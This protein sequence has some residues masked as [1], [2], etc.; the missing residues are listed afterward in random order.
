MGYEIKYKF[1]PRK[2]EGSGYNTDLTE[3][4]LVKVGKPFDDTPLEKVAAAI[5]SQM[6]R[7]DIWVVDVEVAELVR[8]QIAFKE[9]KDGKG[10]VLKGKKYSFNESAQMVSEDVIEVT[11]QMVAQQ[12]AMQNGYQPHEILAMQQMPQVPQNMQPH[13]LINNAQM[14]DD[15]YNNP[16]KPVPVKQNPTPTVAINPKKRLYDVYFEPDHPHLMAEA[17]RLNLKFSRDK[18]YAVHEIIQSPT[19]R[20]DANKI[21]LTNDD[22]RIV[23]VDEKYFA[24]AGLGL[25]ADKQLGF[26]GSNGKRERKPKLAFEGEMYMDGAHPEMQRTIQS[27]FPLDDGTIPGDLMA[28]PDIRKQRPR[29]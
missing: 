8:K 11:S 2:E 29:R 13:E 20:L 16:N 22:G 28:M 7:R 9:C 5:M 21:A 1:H 17:K 24:S 12:Q 14:L 27:N 25:M 10:I 3:E 26:S 15:L 4:K 23:T 18:R 19:G 6:A